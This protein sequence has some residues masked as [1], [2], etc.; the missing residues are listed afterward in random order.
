MLDSEGKTELKQCDQ[1]NQRTEFT[2]KKSISIPPKNLIIIIDKLPQGI[3]PNCSIKFPLLLSV[4]EY[5]ENGNQVLYNLYLLIENSE[6]SNREN[7]KC[8][9]KN[10]LNDRWYLFYNGNILEVSQDDILKAKGYIGFY[11][12]TIV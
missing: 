10:H 1:C 8:Y 3:K 9:C 11:E 2:R 12:Q 6:D 5:T 4:S 7:N